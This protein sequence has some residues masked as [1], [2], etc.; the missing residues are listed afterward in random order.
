MVAVWQRVV[1][2]AGE[3]EG[4]SM[5][6]A[7]LEMRHP[8]LDTTA[9]RERMLKHYMSVSWQDLGKLL[10][11][12]NLLGAFLLHTA[13][14]LYGTAGYIG[15]RQQSVFCIANTGLQQCASVHDCIGSPIC[16]PS[17]IGRLMHLC[18]HTL[19]EIRCDFSIIWAWV[20]GHSWPCR[21]PAWWTALGGEGLYALWL[22]F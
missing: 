21:L 12:A 6:F 16:L 3:I 11:S 17:S 22:A 19:Q 18:Q 2:V 4:G 7:P 5:H 8:L 15:C 13:L 9:L 20:C 10:A 14:Q 1:A